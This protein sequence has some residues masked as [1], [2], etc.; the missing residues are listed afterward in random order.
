MV[1][2][3]SR[4]PT[5]PA[6]ARLVLA[7]TARAGVLARLLDVAVFRRLLG[8]PG[9]RAASVRLGADIASDVAISPGVFIRF[10]PN[11]S[12]GAGTRFSRRVRNEALARS[13]SAAAACSTT[14]SWCSR[15]STTSTASTSKP[16]SDR[17]RSVTTCGCRSASSCCRE[18][19]I[20]DAAVIATGSL[21]T[22]DVAPY[23]VVAGNPARVVRER[24]RLPFR[25]VPSE[26]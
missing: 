7:V 25:Y 16:T 1:G 21:V 20:G 10:P 13:R 4:G 23:A 15:L 14:T 3:D 5:M 6:H 18:L 11:V 17:S 9:R 26:W 2:H 8:G 19:Q 12:I 24:A 22:R